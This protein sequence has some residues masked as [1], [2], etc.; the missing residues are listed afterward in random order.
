LVKGIIVEKATLIVSHC[1]PLTSHPE[2]NE[3]LN[4]QTDQSLSSVRGEI[5]PLWQNLYMR[6]FILAWKK[7]GWEQKFGTRIVICR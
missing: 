6:R 2:A 4:G 1:I 5:S 3:Q 7:Q